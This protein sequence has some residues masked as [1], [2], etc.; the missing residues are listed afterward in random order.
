VIC[1]IKT[2]KMKSEKLKLQNTELT[3]VF[4]RVDLPYQDQDL[5]ITKIVCYFNFKEPTIFLIGEIIRQ[6][7]RVKLFDR[8]DEAREY[9]KEY[10]SEKYKTYL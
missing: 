7:D 8:E 1:Q 6:D 5:Q 3:L 10:I 9:A 2:V 4:D